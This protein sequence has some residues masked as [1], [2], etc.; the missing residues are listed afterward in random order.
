[1]DWLPPEAIG[2]WWHMPQPNGTRA[3]EK[4]EQEGYSERFTS[5]LYA[6]SEG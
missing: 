4:P 5:R 2:N 6:C 1:M 3:G